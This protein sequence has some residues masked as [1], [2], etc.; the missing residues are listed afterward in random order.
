MPE[1]QLDLRATSSPGHR[2]GRSP[3]G[4]M[5]LSTGCRHGSTGPL[6]LGLPRELLH[7]ATTGLLQGSAQL[8]P[9]LEGP[10]RLSKLCAD[11]LERGK[12]QLVYKR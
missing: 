1:V 10:H 7:L 5:S 3:R 8:S 11:L 9:H 2:S 6:Q 4:E 12:R